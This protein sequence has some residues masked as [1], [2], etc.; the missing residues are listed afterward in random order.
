M[1][2]LEFRQALG[3]AIQT[4]SRH[5]HSAAVRDNYANVSTLTHMSHARHMRAQL[6]VGHLHQRMLDESERD[7]P[8]LARLVDAVAKTGDIHR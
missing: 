6:G 7:G 3:I 2:S 8:A 5:C 1:C 4:N